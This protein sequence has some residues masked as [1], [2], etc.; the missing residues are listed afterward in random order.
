VGIGVIGEFE[1]GVEPLVEHRGTLIALTGDIELSLVDENR[2]G[3]LLRLQRCHESCRDSLKVAN[4]PQLSNNRA[5]IYRDRHTT[6]WRSLSG[7]M[8]AGQQRRSQNM[9]PGRPGKHS[10]HFVDDRAWRSPEGTRRVRARF[11]GASMPSVSGLLHPNLRV[12]RSLLPSKDPVN[13]G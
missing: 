11:S 4:V 1:T 12:Q 5:V 3:R 10:I 8:H 6:P 9:P 2:G 7:R 13:F